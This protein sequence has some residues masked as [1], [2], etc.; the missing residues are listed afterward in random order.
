MTYDHAAIDDDSFS[1]LGVFGSRQS[2][3][4]QSVTMASPKQQTC[5]SMLLCSIQSNQPLHPK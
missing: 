3:L 4:L 5:A 2:M 1:D